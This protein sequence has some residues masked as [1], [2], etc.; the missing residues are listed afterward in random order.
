MDP[1][2]TLLKARAAAGLTQRA[3]SE[4]SGV[5]QP[6]IA[7]YEKGRVVPTV[8]TLERL[9]TACRPRPSQVLVRH[10]QEVLDLVA[11]AGGEQALK[12]LDGRH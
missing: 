6:S 9:L 7:A 5:T 8:Q 10:R 11:S 2:S 12:R 1:A 3:L 4:L